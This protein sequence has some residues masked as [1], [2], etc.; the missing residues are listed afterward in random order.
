MAYLIWLFGIQSYCN[1]RFVCGNGLF[2]CF[3]QERKEIL[4]A[5]NQMQKNNKAWFITKSALAIEKKCLTYF[6]IDDLLDYIEKLTMLWL[7]ETNLLKTEI[8]R[9]RK[10][11]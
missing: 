10:L 2:E 11:I 4:E 9:K 5:V 3:P 1:Y 6:F 7:T 8:F